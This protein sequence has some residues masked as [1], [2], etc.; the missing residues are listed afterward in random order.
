MK[1]VHRELILLGVILL[2]ALVVRIWGISHDLPYIYHPDEP[3]YVNISQTIFKTGDLNP[4]FFNYPSLFFYINSFAYIPYYLF[5]KLLGVFASPS[6]ILA[7]TS[8]AMGVTKSPMP[9]AVLFGRIIT[10]AFGIGGIGLTFLI[11][12]QLTSRASIGLVAALLMAISPSNVIHSRFVT[13]DTFVV[14]FAAASFLAT[15]LVYQQGKTWHYIVAGLCIGFTASS[16]YNGALIVLPLLVA[17]FLRHGKKAMKEWNIYL[18]LFFCGLGFVAST[19][20]ALIDFSEF[21]ADLRF[22]SQHYSTGHAGME[23]NTLEWYLSYMWQTAGIIYILGA[24]EILRGAYRRS[25]KLILLSVFPLAYFIF[26]SSFM[27]RNDRT[28]L[29]LTP[30]LF[31]LAASFFV[32][33]LRRIKTFQSKALRRFS[34]LAIACL[35]IVGL[36]SPTSKTIANGIRITT[37][38]SR[39]TARVWISD[40]LPSGARIA[41]ESYSPFVD[42]SRFS[43]QGF[44]RLIEHGPEWYVEQDFDYLV[45]SQGMYG[46]FYR[47]PERYSIEISQYETLFRR[48]HLMKFFTDGGYEVRIYRVK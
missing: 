47:E 19:P 38:D 18:A 39:E 5:G 7:P 45:F 3:G 10:I 44:E 27:V 46:R 34:S 4:H 22:E 33:L 12:K 48:F 29:P 25:R 40:N 14:F 43:I 17:H 26:I 42:P 1:R 23:G 28:F 37:V 31:L 21:L 24:L 20:F 41:I 15:I 16:K 8:L 11:G 9:T 6:S 35:L 30:F 32:H 36:I 2:I 13:P